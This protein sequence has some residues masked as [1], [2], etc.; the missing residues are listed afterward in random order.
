[1]QQ[2]CPERTHHSESEQLEERIYLIVTLS[3]HGY[4]TRA[5]V[6][7]KIHEILPVSRT[8]GTASR[9]RNTSTSTNAVVVAVS[10]ISAARVTR[11]Q[12][13]SP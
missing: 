6:A 4:S 1:M 2:V 9:R 11:K 12:L 13:F 10:A 8:R 3:M 5:Q 7:S